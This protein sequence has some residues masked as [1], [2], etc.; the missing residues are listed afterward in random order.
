MKY[1]VQGIL[2]DNTGKNTIETPIDSIKSD[3]YMSTIEF[4]MK[5]HKSS[6][7]YLYRAIEIETQ[8]VVFS[9]TKNKFAW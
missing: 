8:K 7:H 9:T 4:I 1:L 3:D 5:R 6:P 2:I